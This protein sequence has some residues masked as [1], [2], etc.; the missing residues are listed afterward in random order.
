MKQVTRLFI[1]SVQNLVFQFL[2]IAQ[3]SFNRKCDKNMFRFYRMPLLSLA[4]L[5]MWFLFGDLARGC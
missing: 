5:V 2:D 1:K 4:L 3:L